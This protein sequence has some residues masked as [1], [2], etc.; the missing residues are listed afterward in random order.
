M[1]SRV[2]DELP[3]AIV[4]TF[5]GF[6]TV[7]AATAAG[8]LAAAAV[9]VATAAATAAVCS[10]GSPSLLAAP[11]V[12]GFATV[13]AA[14]ATGSVA[15]AAAAVTTKAETAEASS[16]GL[17]SLLSA[18]MAATSRAAPVGVCSAIIAL[19][20]S[21]FCWFRLRLFEWRTVAAFPVL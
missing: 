3:T 5:A 19:T 6:A 11:V 13:L 7:V 21:V 16:P 8:L 17:R 15:A 12:P 18:T 2:A 14:T 9:A 4:D 20:A 1:R 10:L